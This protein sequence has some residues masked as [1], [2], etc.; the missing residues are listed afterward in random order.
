[1]KKAAADHRNQ[2]RPS[3]CE[4]VC[5]EMCITAQAVFYCN[6]RAPSLIMTS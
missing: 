4:N 1:M 5:Y 2:P 3:V 6:F